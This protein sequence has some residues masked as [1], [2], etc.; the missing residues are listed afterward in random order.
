IPPDWPVEAELY[1]ED[2]P[3]PEK[4]FEVED[5]PGAYPRM[6]VRVTKLPVGKLNIDLS[7]ILWFPATVGDEGP[8][9]F[10]AGMDAPP[11]VTV[12]DI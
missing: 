2:D 5:F 1:Y 6:G 10:A 11:S 4:S 3:E 9:P 12:Q 7:V 8:V